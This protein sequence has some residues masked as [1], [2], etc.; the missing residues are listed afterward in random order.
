MGS[1]R[2]ARRE[3]LKRNIVIWG[4]LVAIIIAWFALY[5]YCAVMSG[6]I[7]TYTYTPAKMSE[8]QDG[9]TISIDKSKNWRDTTHHDELPY[10][11]QYDATVC[12]ASGYD[13]VNWSAQIEFDG[14]VEIDDGWNGEYEIVGNTV[15]FTA[16][17]PVDILPAGDEKTFGA[18]LYTHNSCKIAGCV[19]SGN[20]NVNFRESGAFWIL[21]ELSIAYVFMVIFH[22]LYYFKTEKLKKQVDHDDVII[23]QAIKT[24]TGFIDAKDAY[25]KD[26]SARVAMYAK[27]I[28]KRRGLSEKFVRELYYIALLHDCGKIAIPDDI[29]KKEGSL[30]TE[31]FAIVKT[32]TTKG[33]ELLKKFT[34]IEGIGDGAHYHH[35]RYDGYGY[36]AG[37]EGEEIPL[38]ARIIGVADAYDAMSS[39]RCYRKALSHEKI[40]EELLNNSGKQFD[41]MFVPILVGMIEDGFVDTV[42]AKYPLE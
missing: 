2:K 3:Y 6:S 9:I 36:P 17:D 29:L 28:A 31:E 12:N 24:L 22:V 39:N 41:P 34:A 42:K 37:L 30:T 5:K 25:T 23:E 18:I 14:P 32:H 16:A 21:L 27:E 11:A 26:H 38:C 7:H 33:S 8:P 35:E 4:V 1:H 40:M 20:W 13:F 15:M 19:I 10:G